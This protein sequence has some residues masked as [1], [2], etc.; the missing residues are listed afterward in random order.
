[1]RGG[2]SAARGVMTDKVF[3]DKDADVDWDLVLGIREVGTL[4]KLQ[5]AEANADSKYDLG[6]RV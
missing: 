1:M 4:G 3:A 6:F 5:Q 2:W